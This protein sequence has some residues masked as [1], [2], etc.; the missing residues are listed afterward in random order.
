MIQPLKDTTSV[1]S[2]CWVDVPE[3]LPVEDDFFLPTILLVVGSEFE[4]LAPPGIF[5]ELDQV[6]AEE[7]LAHVFDDLGTPDNLLVWKADE[8]VAADWK[9]FGRDWKTKVKIVAPPPHEARLQSQLIG[10][11]GLSGKRAP[12]FPVAA[13]AAG[14]VRNVSRLRSARKRRATLEKAA[15]IDPANTGALALL[16]EMEFQ[17]GRY[18]QAFSLAMQIKE[19]DAELLRRRGTDWWN[20]RST[21][22]LLR[23]LH[24]MMLCHWHLGRFVEAADEGTRLM[25]IDARDHMG[26]RFYI[27]LFLLLADRHEEA[28]SF[29]R[30]YARNYPGDMPNAWLSFAWAFTLGLEGDDQGARKK[31]REGMLANIYIAPRLL[32]ERP[33]PEDLFHPGE[34]DEPQSALEFAG[35]FGGLWD[36]EASAVRT[37]RDSYVEMRPVI[38]ELVERRTKLADMMDQRYDTEYRAKWTKMV[39][40]EEEF[41]RKIIE[42][43][44]EEPGSGGR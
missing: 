38:R 25:K 34:R 33:P 28:S 17:A 16:A 12:E 19:I 42:A 18:E 36:R 2:L 30:R 32:G 11:G 35:S 27:P 10:E 14:L 7:W 1:W 23:A 40:D 3:P 15:Q 4:P 41:V 26:A 22:P 9:F 29:F 5:P 20:D 13:V 24:T 21:R 37:L 31:Y 43:G 39:D 8:W 44:G 6:Q